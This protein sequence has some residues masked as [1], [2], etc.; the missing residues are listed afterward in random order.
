MSWYTPTVVTTKR[1]SQAKELKTV[2]E[3]AKQQRSNSPIRCGTNAATNCNEWIELSL[4]CRGASRSSGRPIW[5]QSKPPSVGRLVLAD[6]RRALL[7]G[8]RGLQ[9]IA[10]C[11]C[12]SS[13]SRRLTLMVNAIKNA[14]G[15]AAA[16][17]LTACATEPAWLSALWTKMPVWHFHSLVRWECHLVCKMHLNGKRWNE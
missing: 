14:V 5:S 12:S 8:I 11:C 1:G 7:K 3:V 13:I 17:G 9:T 4:S 16:R 2:V 10:G 6:I 15:T